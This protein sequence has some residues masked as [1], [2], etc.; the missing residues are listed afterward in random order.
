MDIQEKLDLLIDN[1]EMAV[2][3]F[4]GNVDLLVKF[5]NKFSDDPTYDKLITAVN[6]KNY[7]HIEMFAHTMKGVAA[8]LGLDLLSSNASDI[9]NAV[10]RDELT[11]IDAMMEVLETEYQRVIKIIKA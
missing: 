1:K 8:N 7:E 11:E 10:R 2:A 5:L 3:R 6:E 4:G 9:V